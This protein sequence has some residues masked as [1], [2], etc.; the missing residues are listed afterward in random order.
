MVIVFESG[1]VCPAP[2]PPVSLDRLAYSVSRKIEMRMKVQ[3]FA[4]SLA[5]C[6]AVPGIA[7][8]AVPV[9]AVAPEISDALRIRLEQR[10]VDVAQL[11]QRMA[12]NGRDGSEF[13]QRLEA[14]GVDSIELR[15]RVESGQ[16]PFAP[17]TRPVAT[18]EQRSQFRE[19]VT[20][21]R[22]ENG[23]PVRP[24]MTPQMR[25]RQQTTPLQRRSAMN[26]AI[27]RTG[28]DRSEFRNDVQSGTTLTPEQRSARRE[29]LRAQWQSRR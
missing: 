13:R 12:D 2:F 19:Q 3:L 22:M 28:V 21:R 8:E 23:N 9:P 20:D 29:T 11:Q 24:S 26:S 7:Q 14:R 27:D 16:R 25:V 18:P 4:V 5:M 15:S 6:V 17:G 10:G 1:V